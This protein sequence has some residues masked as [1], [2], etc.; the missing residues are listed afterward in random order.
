[1]LAYNGEWEWADIPSWPIGVT[2]K[3]DG[4]RALTQNGTVLTRTGKPIP[5]RYISAY[6][7]SLPSNLDG[8][9][10]TIN[11]DTGHEDNFYTCSGK[12]RSVDG[13]PMFKFYVF[14]YIMAGTTYVDRVRR[15]AEL[16][17]QPHLF[18]HILHP[19]LMT[20]PEVT[21]E[22]FRAETEERGSEG[23]ILRKLDAPYKHGRCTLNEGYMFKMVPHKKEIGVIV[24][25]TPNQFHPDRIG[26]IKVNSLLHGTISVGTG[27][28][29][30][31]SKDMRMWPQKYIGQ[32]IIFRHKCNRKKDAPSSAS[33]VSLGNEHNL[34]TTPA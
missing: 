27:F 3:K 15:A 11:L 4:I 30:S 24:G 13:S 21:Q 18:C 6:L 28:S 26:A 19:V 2:V 16:V 29:M 34:H 1:M 14:D 22:C 8:E 5:N 20:S 33:M 10:V 31:Q 17:P 23:I 25:F 32:N 12:I 7:S 9:V